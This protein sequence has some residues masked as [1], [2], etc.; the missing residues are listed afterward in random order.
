MRSTARRRARVVTFGAVDLPAVR[1]EVAAAFA[2]YEV[3]L[4]ANDAAALGRF[5]WDDPRAIRY[6]AG[7]NLHGAAAIAAFRAQ[8]GAGD[9]ARDLARTT[10]TCFGEDFATACTL[11]RRRESGRTGRQMQCWARLPEGWRIVAAHVSL[12]DFPWPKG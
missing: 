4:I 9:L 1:A 2:A 12:L 7:E 8:R 5:F 10:I 6:G 3:A 11:F